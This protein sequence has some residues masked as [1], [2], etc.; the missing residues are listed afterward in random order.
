MDD[1]RCNVFV[2]RDGTR[3]RLKPAL[4]LRWSKD[5]RLQQ[6]ITVNKFA[7]HDHYVET[8]IEWEDIP[9]ET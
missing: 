9:T 8:I 1:L 4:Q 2:H 7:D 6:A 5:G 3:E